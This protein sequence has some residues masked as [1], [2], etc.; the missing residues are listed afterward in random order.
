[1]AKRNLDIQEKSLSIAR[2]RLKEGVATKLDESQ[3]LASVE[4]TRAAIPLLE[5]QHR[6]AANHL[7]TLL[8]MPPRD[9]AE[10]LGQTVIPMASPRVAVG[11]PSQLLCRRPDVRSAERA[12]A[13]QSEQIGIAMTEFYPHIAIDGTLGFESSNFAELFERRSLTASIRTFVPLEY[14]QLR[15]TS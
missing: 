3:A 13:A 14:S 4:Q 11:I 15:S 8:G 7:C 2:Q 10:M 12:V 9:L 5:I 6:Q 1:M